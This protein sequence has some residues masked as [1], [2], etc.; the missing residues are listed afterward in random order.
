MPYA[1]THLII[2]NHIAEKTTLINDTG[3]LFL[4]S[5]S[6]DSVHSRKNYC[7]IMKEQSH[8]CIQGE[9]WGK[10]KDSEAW[11]ENV[12]NEANKF[13]EMMDIN[14]FLGYFIHIITDIYYD[15][16][17]TKPYKKEYLNIPL[18]D[19]DYKI[20]VDKQQNNDIELFNEY[21]NKNYIIKS[22]NNC[23]NEK[24]SDIINL[25]D[26]LLYKEIIIN[27]YYNQVIQ[28]IKMESKLVHLTLDE[29]IK[30]I[31]NYTDVIAQNII[32]L[33]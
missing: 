8:F 30:F 32:K 9:C 29:N 16:N 17:V 11:L 28:P 4:G 22:L 24:F 2:A 23:T 25:D 27:R 13:K 3:K 12:Y 10:I 14:Y 21:K 6:P 7:P 5:I 18:T 20:L 31:I 19:N 33:I 1:M 26:T 15:E